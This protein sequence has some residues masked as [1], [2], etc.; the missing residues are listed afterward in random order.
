MDY[1]IYECI[2]DQSGINHIFFINLYTDFGYE[3]TAYDEDEGETSTYY[4]PSNYEG[5]RSSKSAQKKHK[6]RIKS[7]TNRSNEVGTDLPY[8]HYSTGTQ[9]STIFGK[10]PANFNVGTTPTKRMRTAS[11]QRVVSPFAMAHL[12][13]F[14]NFYVRKPYF[15]CGCL[16]IISTGFCL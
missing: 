14:S 4:L 5:C 16:T 15:S 11:Q 3:E 7:Y 13:V 9:P 8:V 6:N 1:F 10:R 12:F 2:V